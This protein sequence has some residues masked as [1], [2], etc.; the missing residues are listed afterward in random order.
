M[1]GPAG[2]H[3]DAR[4]FVV[5]SRAQPAHT[6]RGR[7]L[8]AISAAICAAARA[9][10]SSKNARISAGLHGPSHGTSIR[11]STSTVAA[12]MPCSCDFSVS[13]FCGLGECNGHLLW[14]ERNGRADDKAAARAGLAVRG[15]RALEARLHAA[16]DEDWIQKTLLPS[17]A[18]L[19][20]VMR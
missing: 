16:K 4:R 13:H 1:S 3:A 19:G 11:A 15:A 5:V 20:D 7:V 17:A 2:L 9:W 18:G 6:G 10:A 12:D 14:K 8:H